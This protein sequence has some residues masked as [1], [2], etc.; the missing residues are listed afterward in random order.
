M[1]VFGSNVGHGNAVTG[2]NELKN[3]LIVVVFLRISCAQVCEMADK[4]TPIS[5]TK[6]QFF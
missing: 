6:I 5:I 4:R 3:C 1:A 2:K